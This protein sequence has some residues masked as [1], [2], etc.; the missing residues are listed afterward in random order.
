[1]DPVASSGQWFRAV[2]TGVESYRPYEFYDDPTAGM[3]GSAAISGHVVAVGFAQGFPPQAIT[4]FVVLATIINDNPPEGTWTPGTNSHGESVQYAGSPCT[5]TL[6]NVKLTASFAVTDITN[7]PPVWRPPYF[8][9][10]PFLVAENEDQAAWYCWNPDDPD[11]NHI[12]KGDYYVPTWDFGDIPAGQSATRT[13]LFSVA[14]AGL[15]FSDPRY[16]V[17]L[18]SFSNH[19]DILFNRSR[20]LKISN[21]LDALALDDGSMF[22]QGAEFAS[23]VSVFHYPEEESSSMDFGDAPAPLY[24][25][26][27][28]NNG[29]R[30]TI[31]PGTFM[32]NLIDPEPDGQPNASA[33]GDDIANLADED[34][35]SFAGPL[36]AGGNAT[37]LVACSVSGYVWAWMDFNTNG[38]WSDTGEMIAGGATVTSGVNTLVFSILSNSVIGKTFARFRFTSQP[39]ALAPTGPA[40]DGEVEDYGVTIE[41]KEESGLDFGD[42]WDS[43]GMGI[44]YPTLLVNNGA[45]HVLVHGV[46]LGNYVDAEADGQPTP[47]ADGDDNNPPLGIDDEDGVFLPSVLYAGST[48][49]VTIVAS[50]TGYL[51]AWIDFNANSSWAD[52]GEQVFNQTPLAPGSN[53]LWFNVPMPPQ[54]VSGGPHSRWRFTTNLIPG[55]SYTGMAANGEVEDHE[56][57][58]EA[59]DFGDAP[60]SYAT[61]LINDG[62]RHRT[63][64]A[65]WLGVVSPD[66]EPDGQPDGSATGDDLSNTADEEGVSILSPLVRGATGRV[67]VVASTNGVLEAF[68]DWNADGDWA[69][70]GESLPSISAGTGTN[71]L[72]VAVPPDSAI[73]PTYARFRFGSVGSG[74]W[75]GFAPDGEVEDYMFTIYQ[76]PP[77]ADVVITNVYLVPT[78]D[79]ITLVWQAESNVLY[80]TQQTTNMLDA[81]NAVWTPWGGYI[82]GPT[83]WQNDTNIGAGV[84]SYRLAIP[85]PAP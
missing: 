2:G 65:Y 83:N 62:A 67:A 42:A 45:R 37:A 66:I 22:P 46:Y 24:P 50:T 49:Q 14:G 36:F 6:R 15:P 64:S 55:L 54:L 5:G 3:A 4:S 13:L 20:S 29:A 61:L 79:K 57:R 53:V 56:L 18:A 39:T 7:V 51:N 27:L 26:L 43:G 35:V 23:D 30:H 80:E 63:P 47:S 19:M 11:P 58:L 71:V 21:W 1:L 44:S 75:T 68:I 32:G 12:P 82:I 85:Y 8:K 69:D 52:P 48:A 10:E 16:S 41:Q 76:Q 9:M 34:G 38:S 73:G 84:K 70:A 74:T 25:T 77:A 60:N 59:A 40:A 17:I 78:P 28:V 31:V 81:T 72:T 33:T